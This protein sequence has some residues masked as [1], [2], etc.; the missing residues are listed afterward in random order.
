MNEVER[1]EPALDAARGLRPRLIG[2]VEGE[3]G[4]LPTSFTAPPGAKAKPPAEPVLTYCPDCGINLIT[5]GP[6]QHDHGAGGPP[7][8]PKGHPME[9]KI[10]PANRPTVLGLHGVP[11]LPFHPTHDLHRGLTDD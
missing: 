7:R 6:T 5:T 4:E 3:S 11:A 10:K 2:A 9:E 8:C 1:S